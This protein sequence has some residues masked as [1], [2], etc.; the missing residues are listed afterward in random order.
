MPSTTETLHPAT[1]LC[2]ATGQNLPNLIPALQLQAQRVIILATPAMARS[3]RNLKTAL[4]AHK[5]QV[6]EPINFDDSSPESIMQ[7]AEKIAYQLGEQ[8]L[9]FNATGGHKLM[10]LALSHHLPVA[11]KLH[12]LY[13]ET[14]QDQID[15]LYPK[16]YIQQ[17]PHSLSI[18][19][20]LLVQGWRINDG[21]R[22]QD[23]FALSAAGERKK[24][25]A[26]LA[27]EA[28][29]LARL[30]GE[31]N[32]FANQ[33]LNEGKKTGFHLRIPPKNKRAEALRMAQ[34]L[35]LIS[36]DGATQINFLSNDAAEYFMGG[37]LEEFVGIVL[38]GSQI[39]SS[40]WAQNLKAN[41]QPSGTENEFDGL[42]C[43]RNRLLVIE[44]KTGRFGRILEKDANLVYKL[45][46][47]KQQIGGS[48][49][50]GILLSARDVSH[51]VT[52]R[53]QDTGVKVFSG[54]AI[55]EFSVFVKRW[56][57]GI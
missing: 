47:L 17:M 6:D 49:A 37:W 20:F 29:T 41:H 34:A 50:E 53:A 27:T 16:A 21:E 36:W 23:A 24:L 57:A 9:V 56:I 3:A 52:K 55:S 15:W 48:M 46:Q 10:T 54:E 19:D 8:P 38:K 2:I 30:F 40:D 45:G 25:T 28:E 5:I 33:Y 11:D 26:L 51:E 43:A 13:C 14:R 42:L 32:F 39:P 44:C 4:E 18:Q 12:T 35:N 7:S 22:T 31:M 1:H